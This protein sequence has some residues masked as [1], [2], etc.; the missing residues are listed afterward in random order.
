LVSKIFPENILN[1]V[2]TWMVNRNARQCPT[3]C[4]NDICGLVMM[5]QKEKNNEQK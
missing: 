3:N 2:T 4:A 5:V 1:K